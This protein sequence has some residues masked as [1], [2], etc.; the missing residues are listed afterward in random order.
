MTEQFKEDSGHIHKPFLRPV[1][2]SWIVGCSLCSVGLKDM[3]PVCDSG[4]SSMGLSVETFAL[5]VSA[6]WKVPGCVM[7]IPTPCRW[8]YK[9]TL[10][11][12]KG[13]WQ[14]VS[15]HLKMCIAF[16]QAASLIW[17]HHT[18]NS[19][20]PRPS[21]GHIISLWCCVWKIQ[22]GNQMDLKSAQSKFHLWE[23]TSTAPLSS[24]I[25]HWRSVKGFVLSVL[26]AK[27]SLG[28]G[29]HAE[30]EADKNIQKLN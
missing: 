15:I 16:G 4:D 28:R 30:G 1:I 5:G 7:V 29:R 3:G 11:F 8:E 26:H 13:T 27:G 20:R 2:S 19:Y 24:V 9:F 22:P 25:A 6:A 17:G 14:N 12:W 10:H 21:R 23:S 18:H